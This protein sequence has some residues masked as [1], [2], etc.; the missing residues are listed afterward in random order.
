M[1]YWR[2]KQL[3]TQPDKAALSQPPYSDLDK[4]NK[5]KTGTRFT[6]KVLVYQQTLQKINTLLFADEKVIITDSVDKL[7]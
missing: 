3:I 1:N 2:Y 5:T 6:Q 4:R 7:Q